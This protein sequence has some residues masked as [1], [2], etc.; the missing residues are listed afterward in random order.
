MS[1]YITQHQTDTLNCT[2]ENLS[3]DTATFQ[4][5]L[6]HIVFFSKTLKAYWKLHGYFWR[7]NKNFRDAGFS[8]DGQQLE[9][10]EF[11]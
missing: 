10:H 11:F 9:A 7:S 8:R 1:R 6:M 2:Y 4:K 3:K 5:G